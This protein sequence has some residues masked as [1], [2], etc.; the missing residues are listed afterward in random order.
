[1]T[2][3]HVSDSEVFLCGA[4]S[5]TVSAIDATTGNVT[6]FLEIRTLLLRLW[7]CVRSMFP[8]LRML[9]AANIP[10]GIGIGVIAV[11]G[12]YLYLQFSGYIAPLSPA[13]R[14]RRN[15]ALPIAQAK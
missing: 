9:L 7:L 4:D 6:T 2:R 10:T 8:L 15:V 3:E 14:C 12:N 5:G 13:V 11:H 1:L